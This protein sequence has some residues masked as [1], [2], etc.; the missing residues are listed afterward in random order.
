MYPIEITT[1]VNGEAQSAVLPPRGGGAPNVPEGFVPGPDV[2]VGDLPVVAAVWQQRNAGRPRGGNRLLQCR[3]C[4]LELVCK[5]R[6][7]DHP[8]IPQNLYR[9]SGGATNDERFEQIGQ[10]SVK[11]AFTALDSK[12]SAALA[13][14][15]VGRHSSRLGMFGSLRRQSECGPNCLGSRAWINPFTGAYPRN[16]S[17][18][19][20]NSHAGHAHTGTS[21]RILVEIRRP[22]HDAESRRDLLRRR[23]S[24]SRR[25]SMPGARRNP[26]QCNMYNNV[27]YR[28]YN[29]TRHDQSFQLF[30]GRISHGARRPRPSAPGL[31]RRLIRSNPLRESMALD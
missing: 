20:N 18:T 31:E 26:G 17:A 14:I 23:R 3:H 11:H 1:V 27:S 22:E 8:V 10:S 4:R 13:A 28:R 12:T 7:T 30:D 24:T 25:M 19:P 6:N 9:M 21:H 15:G 16:D 5:C 2:I 29:V